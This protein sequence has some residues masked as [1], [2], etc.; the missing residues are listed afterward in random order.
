MEGYVTLDCSE[1]RLPVRY[2]SMHKDW[3]ALSL[4]PD[5][6]PFLSQDDLRVQIEVKGMP[7]DANKQKTNYVT[8][9]GR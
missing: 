9:S 2:F 6:V 1:H 4:R 8:D 7:V 3:N 5:L